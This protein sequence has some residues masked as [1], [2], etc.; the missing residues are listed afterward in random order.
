MV[1]DPDKVSADVLT[2]AAE[3]NYRAI[4]DAAND[5]IFVHEIETGRIL[6]V[7]QRMCELYGVT[8]EEAR[9][10][11]VD[12][13]SANEPPYST[14]EAVHWIREAAA[15]K[16]QLF[17]WIA[18]DKSGRFF[19][20]EVNLKLAKLNNREVMLA[21]VRDISVRKRALEELHESEQR[22]AKV[23]NSNPQP[24][25]ITTVRDGRYLNVN[26]SFLAISGYEREELIGHTSLELK[27]WE[28]PKQREKFIDELLA[29]GSV[30]NFETGFRT[31]QGD[32]RTF[33]SSAE[34]LVI[35]GEQCLLVASSDITELRIAE[36][37]ARQQLR[38][39]SAK[40]IQAQEDER[41]R[42][43]RELHDGLS[44]KMA[45]LSIEL[46]YISRHADMGETK[47]RA[48]ME[49]MRSDA[50]E[51][52]DDIHRISHQLHPSKLDHLG[53][54]KATKS[55][56]QEFSEYY[57]LEIDFRDI[58]LLTR[59]PK[60]LELCAFR[61]IQESLRNVVKHS[62]ANRAAVN[63]G[64]SD[65]MLSI[66]V[67]D[68]GC[69]FDSLSDKTSSGLGFIGMRER[70]KA[71]GGKLSIFSE[72]NHG[73]RVE[74]LIPIAKAEGDQ[75]L[76]GPNNQQSITENVLLTPTLGDTTLE[77]I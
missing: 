10:L 45:L 43:A 29:A 26:D 15:G 52:S 17:E 77:E 14:Q 16:P 70:L 25:S 2:D 30:R 46:E 8:V 59:L 66:V 61:I 64:Q 23:F 22:F 28:T 53:L 49:S 62:R 38:D 50:E 27:I 34:Q 63:L 21:V 4:F 41:S 3:A 40:L 31:K 18:R 24:L 35:D 75:R 9:Q 32:F 11:T 68:S 48:S 19:W 72:P 20:V 71:V 67:T 51:I 7:N 58:P 55:F 76:E 56:I 47:L 69:G 1:S 73:T 74:A 60:D 37:V 5:A 13:L 36:N 39:L 33:L 57:R 6:D 44:Q 42:V 65:Q 12:D 54:V